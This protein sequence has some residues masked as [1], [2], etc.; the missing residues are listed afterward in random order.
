[1]KKI[2][3]LILVSTVF[4]A[5]SC[6]LDINDNPNNPQTSGN[7]YLLSSGIAWSAAVLGGDGQLIGGLWSQHYT[8]NT[9]SNQYKLIDS[10]GLQTSDYTNIWD[11]MWAGSLK[12]LIILRDQSKTE[13][14][15][16]FYGASLIMIAFNMHFLVDLYGSIP[17]DDALLGDENLNPKFEE[18]EV[19]NGKLILMLDEA[20]SSFPDQDLVTLGSQDFLFQGDVEGWKKFA[21]TLKLKILMRDFAA[22]QSTIQ[23]LL[24]EELLDLDV[25]LASFDNKPKGSNPLF[26]NDRRDLNTGVNI[27]ASRTFLSYL[28]AN[29]DPRIENF[30]EVN[31]DGIYVGIEQGNYEQTPTLP[32]G[33]TSVAK[34][35]PYD[36]VF[37]MSEAESYF[38]QAEAWARIGNS[39]N[40]KSFYEK[41]VT[42]SFK[43]IYSDKPGQVGASVWTADKPFDATPFLGAGGKY[44]YKSAGSMEEQVEQIIIQKWVAACRAQAWDSFFDQN[45]T[46]YPKISSVDYEDEAYV[47]G[48]YVLSYNSVLEDVF[49]RRMLYPKTSLDYNLNT[50][51]VVPLSE[52]MW[53]HK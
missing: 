46:G 2:K 26:E 10:Y 44:E 37:F 27:K 18:G 29:S 42:A 16:D 52:K 34:I 43:R 24:G 5:T 25:K 21:R 48:Q 45:R 47:P 33:A 17:V 22:N 3:L 4:F 36:P 31:E 13:E 38:L 20:I 8:Q 6:D 49:P 40:A 50:P 28:Q 12:D 30:F 35:S 32:A 19:V 15:Y 51:K 11:N 39:V 9:T 53:W 1:M 14:A 41:G 23:T 7:E